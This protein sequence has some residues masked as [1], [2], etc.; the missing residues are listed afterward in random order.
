MVQR[1]LPLARPC[2]NKTTRVTVMFGTAILVVRSQQREPIGI[3]EDKEKGG[4][5]RHVSGRLCTP[6]A[7]SAK[8]FVVPWFISRVE[9]NIM[10]NGQIRMPAEQVM[11]MMNSALVHFSCALGR[12]WFSWVCRIPSTSVQAVATECP[13]QVV[14]GCPLPLH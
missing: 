7:R 14:H 8:V 4:W 3:W 5:C 12:S 6:R 2:L 10:G 13:H 11:A 9:T 1:V